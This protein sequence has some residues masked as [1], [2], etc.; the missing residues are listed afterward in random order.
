MYARVAKWEGSDGTLLRRAA[1]EIKADAPAG[2]PPGV[3]AKGFLM[4]I[5]PDNGRSLAIS[6]YETEED[7]RKGD[8]ALN[9]MTPRVDDGG[10]RVSVE[11]YEVGVDVRM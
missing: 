1:D 10:K 6:L 9:A 4:L 3:P 7:L 2:P 11:M 8:E 5:D